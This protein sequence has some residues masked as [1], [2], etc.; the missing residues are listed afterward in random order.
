MASFE[1]YFFNGLVFLIAGG[2][3]YMERVNERIVRKPWWLR[4]GTRCAILMLG[5]LAAF[6][7]P[8]IYALFQG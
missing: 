8:L 2:A 7:M 6:V 3:L 4:I 5:I 1:D